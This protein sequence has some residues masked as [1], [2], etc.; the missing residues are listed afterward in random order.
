VEFLVIVTGGVES[1]DPTG[2]NMWYEIAWD[3]GDGATATGS[4]AYHTFAAPDTYTVRATA[5]DD[6]GAEAEISSEIVVLA[7]TL[8]IAAS[9]EPPSGSDI[10]AGSD[11]VRFDA[12]AEVC[13]FDPQDDLQYGRFLFRWSTSDTTLEGRRPSYVFPAATTDTQWVFLTATEPSLS[14]TRRDSLFF[15]L[16]SPV[17]NP[18]R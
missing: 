17:L 1:S 4:K 9:S 2:A 13:G 7:D 8:S 12:V 10:T 6:N 5:R 3:F 15:V 18:P 11:T 16:N 14:V